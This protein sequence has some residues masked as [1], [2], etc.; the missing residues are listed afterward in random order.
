MIRKLNNFATN[1]ENISCVIQTE[2]QLHGFKEGQWQDTGARHKRHFDVN[3]VEQ[4]LPLTAVLFAYAY[5]LYVWQNEHD[6][7][8]CT[9]QSL[10]GA[11]P[12]QIHLYQTDL[13]EFNQLP[14]CKCIGN[15]RQYW[16]RVFASFAFTDVII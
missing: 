11:M 15:W 8:L 9:F 6:D 14:V 13:W 2:P 4:S 16:R 12:S 7:S 3:D 1:T 5:S 10:T